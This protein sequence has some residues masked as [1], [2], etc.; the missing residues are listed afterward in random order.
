MRNILYLCVAAIG[1]AGCE[2]TAMET[3][4]RWTDSSMPTGAL[5]NMRWY[6]PEQVKEGATLFRT[7][8]AEC[9]GRD[10]E[11]TPNWRRRGEDGTFPPPP[12]D[13]TAHTWH[14]PLTVLRNTVKQGGVPSGGTMPGFADKLDDRQIDAILAWVQSHWSEEVYTLWLQRA[15]QAR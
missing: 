4:E 8:C 1:L 3:P 9:H 14:H 6:S 12:L 10:A 7:H 2:D 13:G 15:R 5:P 11:G